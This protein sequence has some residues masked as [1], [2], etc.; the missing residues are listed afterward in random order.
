MKNCTF[1][2]T[3]HFT[4][5]FISYI[6]SYFSEH[7]QCASSK[8]DKNF[9]C[10]SLYFPNFAPVLNI[11]KQFLPKIQTNDENYENGDTLEAWGYHVIVCLTPQTRHG[12]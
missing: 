1:L 11:Q 5:V 2:L 4:P 8:L 3:S 6:W 10:L 7:T 12:L 9:P